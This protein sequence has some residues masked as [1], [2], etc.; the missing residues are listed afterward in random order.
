MASPHV[1]G[2]AAQYRQSYPS[3]TPQQV[4]DAL[5]SNATPNVVTGPGTGSP[6]RLLYNGAAGGGGQPTT[7][8]AEFFIR[9]LQAGATDVPLQFTA[10]AGAH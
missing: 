6:N 4:R 8:A 9:S 5:V 7:C 10:A 2:A 3:A 1:A